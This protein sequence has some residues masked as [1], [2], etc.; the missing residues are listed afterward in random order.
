MTF[1][2]PSVKSIVRPRYVTKT[3]VHAPTVIGNEFSY[4]KNNGDTNAPDLRINHYYTKSVAEFE[5]KFSRGWLLRK[6]NS[7][8]LIKKKREIYK[9][10]D[11]SYFDDR[12]IE[13]NKLRQR[14]SPSQRFA[15]SPE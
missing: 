9:F 15:A 14:R 2:I 7:A 13:I 8:S 4:V 1:L 10:S 12:I 3:L 5:E 11:F 6:V